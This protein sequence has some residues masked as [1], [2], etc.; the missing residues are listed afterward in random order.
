MAQIKVDTTCTPKYYLL[1]LS[2]SLVDV[3]LYTPNKPV[4]DMA[5]PVLWIM[6]VGCTVC[7]SLWGEYISCDEARST[8]FSFNAH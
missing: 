3:L 8:T 7:A 2:L 4:L 6:A 5:I 1:S